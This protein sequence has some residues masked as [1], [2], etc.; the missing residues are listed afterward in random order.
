MD[1]DPPRASLNESA[2]DRTGKKLPETKD[3]KPMSF[4][5][6]LMGGAKATAPKQFVDLVEQGKMRVNLVGGN[7]LLL[8]ISVD[9]EV[10][11]EMCQPWKEAL[12]L[13]LLGKSLGYK[14]MKT[15]LAAVWRLSSDFDLLDVGNGFFM[16]KFDC[17]EDREKVISGGS[18]MVFDH[19]LAVSTWSL[20]FIS[21]AAKVKRTLAWVCIPSLDVA[22][23]DESFLLSVA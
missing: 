17:Q 23:Y 21:P 8:V 22:F 13:C 3:G 15:K 4:R 14:T 5:N 1:I 19:Y 6:K 10:M 7:R 11:E 9:K 2:G 20:K 16:A 18:W 12:V